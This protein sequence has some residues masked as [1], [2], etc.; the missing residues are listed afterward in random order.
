MDF[1]ISDE[2]SLLLDSIDDFFQQ[3]PQFNEQYI[4]S[5]ESS[6]FP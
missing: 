2:Q 6:M 1:D 5:C 3:N 4:R